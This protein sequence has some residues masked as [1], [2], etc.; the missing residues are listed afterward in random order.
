MK[1]YSPGDQIGGEYTVQDV[2]GGKTKSGMGVVYLVQ[3]RETPGPVVLKTYQQPLGADAKKQFIS[4][5]HS[6]IN[7]GV[8]ANIVQAYWVREIANRLF[9]C[10]EYIRPDEA[11]R[12]TLTHFVEVGALR[13]EI[14][15]LWASQFCYGMDYARSKGVVAHRDIKPDNKCRI[16][17]E[18][19]S[20]H[21]FKQTANSA[22]A[23]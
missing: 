15:L 13:F 16:I 18:T 6:W 19:G 2:F 3:S 4:E 20:K 22:A 21:G 7:A 1:Q 10:A 12:N 23:F 9:V 17:D 14:V 11:G 8:H 5:A